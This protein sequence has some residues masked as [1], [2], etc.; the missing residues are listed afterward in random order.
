VSVPDKTTNISE[1]ISVRDIRQMR[2]TADLLANSAD[3]HRTA[4]IEHLGLK[5]YIFNALGRAAHRST[6][7]VQL[8]WS[9]GAETIGQNSAKLGDYLYARAQAEQRLPQA[10]ITQLPALN[11]VPEQ[12]V[13]L[14][15]LPTWPWAVDPAKRISPPLSDGLKARRKTRRKAGL[16]NK[17]E[18]V[19]SVPRPGV[20]PIRLDKRKWPNVTLE[21][22]PLAQALEKPA[23]SLAFIATPLAIQENDPD[24]AEALVTAIHRVLD[25]GGHWFLVDAVPAAMPSHWLFAFFPEAWTYASEVA[26]NAYDF[27]NALRQAGFDDI[28]QEEH[29]FRQP[30]TLATAL[31]IANERPG[32]LRHLPDDVYQKG[33]ARLR[34]IV[35][36]TDTP[37]AIQLDS[38]VT[39]IQVRA[40]K[41]KEGKEREKTEDN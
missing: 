6:A 24:H 40:T 22:L 9:T 12:P 37:E 32:I 26:W 14:P 41:G 16:E 34:G 21:E 18:S 27:Y 25:S 39:V 10:A 23:G 31:Q 35:A 17:N 30:V 19:L 20:P 36:E 2:Q 7:G 15:F 13:S 1:T 8:V 4:L 28:Q 33:L 38:E 11:E 3:L 29:T 5:R